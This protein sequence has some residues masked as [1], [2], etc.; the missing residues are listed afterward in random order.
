M[1]SQYF[2]LGISIGSSLHPE[3]WALNYSVEPRAALASVVNN[4]ELCLLLPSVDFLYDEL[5]LLKNRTIHLTSAGMW[6]RDCM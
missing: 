6:R 1:T 3:G 2:L 4:E 5:G